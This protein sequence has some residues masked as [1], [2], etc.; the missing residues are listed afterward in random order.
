MLHRLTRL[1]ALTGALTAAAAPPAHAIV[2]GTPTHRTAGANGSLQRIDSPR[3]DRHVCGATLI[4]PRWALTAGHC[5]R[6]VRGDAAQPL[7]GHPFG[8]RVRFGSVRTDSGGELVDVRAFTRISTSYDPDG[9]LALLQLARPVPA[10]PATLARRRPSDDARARIIGWGFTDPHG[11]ETGYADVDRYP[12]V[13]HTARTRVWPRRV[14]ALKPRQPALCVGG[15][16]GRPGP[17]N[18]DS[19]GPVFVHE[20]DGGTVLAGTVNGGSTTGRPGPSWY[21][22]VSA[23]RRWIRAY[24]SG[25][26]TI[27][28]DP[29]VAAPGLSATASIDGCSG[30]VVRTATAKPTDPALLLT[31]GHCVDPRPAPG[32]ETGPSPARRTVLVNGVDGNARVRTATTGLLLATMTGTDVAVLRLQTT[33]AQLARAGIQALPLA[34]HGPAPGDRVTVLSGTWQ[35][36]FACRVEAVVPTLREGGYVQHDALRYADSRACRP[37]S[38]TSGSPVVDATGAVVAIHNTHAQPEGEPCAPNRP[39]EVGGDGTPVV[40]GGRGYAQ[41]TAGLAARLLAIAGSPPPPRSV[42]RAWPIAPTSTS[43]TR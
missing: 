9:D 20:P 41:Q 5:A 37:G 43:P 17:S 13:L 3:S 27:P 8:W 22:D 2:G 12:R 6:W 39:C 21:T 11:D 40:L 36:R 19:G 24:T 4:A 23:H 42:V 29:P 28:P 30:A 7:T 38:G 32:A 18:M 35:E 25:R 14:C 1:L 16:H 34:D 33:Y 31:N 10:T 26:R 15:E